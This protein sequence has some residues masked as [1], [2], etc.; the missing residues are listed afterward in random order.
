MTV[1]PAL[2]LLL[3]VSTRAFLPPS[4]WSHAVLTRSSLFATYE[5]PPPP[6]PPTFSAQE[7]RANLQ[8]MSRKNY[9][10]RAL[11]QAKK[12]EIEGYIKTLLDSEVGYDLVA[13]SEGQLNALLAGKTYRLLYSTEKMSMLAGLPPFTKITLAMDGQGA[14]DY[15]L[16]FADNWMKNIKTECR[17]KLNR[18]SV[19]NQPILQFAYEKPSVKL[20]NFEVPLPFMKDR[21]NFVLMAWFDGSVWI[22]EGWEGGERGVGDRFFNV[23][24]SD[25]A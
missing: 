23:Y 25:N 15:E 17:Y 20:F 4:G 13:A 8:T 11:P 12:D 2:L 22:E 6:P 24:F 9:D 3:A 21:T 7:L 18:S 10:L 19:T 1:L 14:M 16:S 5:R